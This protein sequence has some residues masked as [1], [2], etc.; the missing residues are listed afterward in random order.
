MILGMSEEML[1]EGY[2]S[3]TNI[4]ISSVVSRIMEEKY[5][6]RSE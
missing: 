4:D 2:E 5:R 6:N 3:I 1:E